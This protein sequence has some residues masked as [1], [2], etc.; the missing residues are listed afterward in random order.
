[1]PSKRRRKRLALEVPA[2]E[3]EPEAAEPTIRCPY[4]DD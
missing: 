2:V 1:M 4:R 3:G